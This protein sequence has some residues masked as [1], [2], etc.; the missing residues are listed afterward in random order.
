VHT[1]RVSSESRAS[2]GQS[3]RVYLCLLTSETVCIGRGARFIKPHGLSS[4]KVYDRTDA[5][6][7]KTP[8]EPHRKEICPPRETNETKVSEKSRFARRLFYLKPGRSSL[9]ICSTI[10]VCMRARTYLV[11]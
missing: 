6:I 10:R 2:D 7:K 9:E 4:K 1:V 3:K 11:R 5:T 8:Q